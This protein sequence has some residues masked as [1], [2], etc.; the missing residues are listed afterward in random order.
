MVQ[1]K[2][3]LDPIARNSEILFG[4]I[5]ALTFTGSISAA[6][7]GRDEVRTIL[8]GA[9]GCNIAWGVVDAVMYLLTAITER[10][11]DLRTARAVRDAATDANARAAIA[12]AL[13]PIV[14]EA[15]P[16]SAFEAVRRRIAALPALP[17]HPRWRADDLRGAAGVFLL[18]VVS[19]FPVVIPFL[20]FERT[21]VAMRVSNGIALLSLFVCGFQLGRYAANRPWRTG[22]AMTLIGA[23]LV[24]LTMA[25]GG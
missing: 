12:D 5:M 23:A 21:L 16:P 4:L 6:T 1:R 11:R 7:A 3:L 18:V 14:A 10:G 17:E 13:P 15:L 9:I 8:L 2:R 24:A 19:T 20:V 22:L 25:L